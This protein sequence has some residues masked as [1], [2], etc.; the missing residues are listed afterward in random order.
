MRKI[1][2]SDIHGSIDSVHH[3][4]DAM[5]HHQIN[6]VIA[7]GDFLYHGPRNPIP[8]HY[9]PKEVIEIL[10]TLDITAVRGNCDAEVDQMMLKFP[11][12]ETSKDFMIGKKQCVMTHGHIINPDAMPDHA[13]ILLYGHV[14]LPIAKKENE[15]FILNPGSI[16]LPKENNPRTYAVLDE[17]SFAIYTLDHQILKS[18]EFQELS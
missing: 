3:L 13:D 5:N 6:E 9:A 4:L 17:S 10:N 14:H 2:V 16:T 18:I 1:V 7:L 12:M 11:I 15:H 8:D